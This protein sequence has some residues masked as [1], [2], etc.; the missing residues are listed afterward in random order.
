MPTVP[1]VDQALDQ[2][3]DGDDAVQILCTSAGLTPQVVA[4]RHACQVDIANSAWAIDADWLA[5]LIAGIPSDSCVAVVDHV[6]GG[7]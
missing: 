2:A 4:A 3:E 5:E 6:L 1:A 7:H